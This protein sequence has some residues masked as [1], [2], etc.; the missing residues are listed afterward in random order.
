ME[1]FFFVFCDQQAWFK[2]R[3]HAPKN[4]NLMLITIV[5]LG[6]CN[7]RKK[8]PFKGFGFTKTL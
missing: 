2:R 7:L 5:E 3:R 1:I 8:E 6:A 4:K